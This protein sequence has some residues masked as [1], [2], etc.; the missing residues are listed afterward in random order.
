LNERK[1]VNDNQSR[2]SGIKKPFIRRLLVYIKVLGWELI[3]NIVL[4][5]SWQL[6]H[7]VLEAVNPPKKELIVILHAWGNIV[8]MIQFLVFAII[9]FWLLEKKDVEELKK[10]LH[11]A[12]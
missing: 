10:D 7:L 4:L 8:V 2:K 5:L 9:K 1:P 6:F 11:N 3:K 12:H